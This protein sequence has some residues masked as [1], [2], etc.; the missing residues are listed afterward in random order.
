MKLSQVS[1][2]CSFFKHLWVWGVFLLLF[3][4]GKR[5]QSGTPLEAVA[6][7][8][9]I[10][11]NSCLFLSPR[12]PLPPLAVLLAKIRDSV[13][14]APALQNGSPLWTLHVFTKLLCE[15]QLPPFLAL[16]PCRWWNTRSSFGLPGRRASQQPA[17]TQ[18]SGLVPCRRSGSPRCTPETHRD[19]LVPLMQKESSRGGW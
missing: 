19:T 12:L 3:W 4:A 11:I 10:C 13:R 14:L 6:W 2:V 7:L 18:A 8:T 9:A 5:G 16:T 15:W 17:V 1:S